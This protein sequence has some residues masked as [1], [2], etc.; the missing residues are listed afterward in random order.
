MKNNNLIPFLFIVLTFSFCSRNENKVKVIEKSFSEEVTVNGKLEFT[1]D[2]Q[3]VPDSIINKPLEEELLKI[4]P[5]VSGKYVWTSNSHLV[6]LPVNGFKPATEYSIRLKDEL[7]KYSKKLFLTGTKEYSFHTPF[8]EL[9]GLQGFW[10]G[11]EGDIPL[12]NLKLE[13]NQPVE[14]S[15]IAAKSNIVINGE[16]RAFSLNADAVSNEVIFNVPDIAVSE[17]NYKANVTIDKGIKPYEG[18]IESEKEMKDQLEIISPFQLKIANIESFHDGMEGNISIYT[19]QK[20]SANNIKKHIRISPSINYDVEIEQNMFIIKSEAFDIHQKYDIGI[21]KGLKGIFG[22]ELKYEYSQPLVFGE[23][24]PTISILNKKEFYVSAKGSKLIELAI[25]NVPRIDISVVKIYENN[26]LSFLNDHPLT[27]YGYDDDYYDYY[28]YGRNIGDLGDEIFTKEVITNELPRKGNH[29][30]LELDFADK[31]T[32]YKGVYWIEIRSA[33]QQWIKSNKIIA[34]S[35]IGLIVKEGKEDITVFANSIKDA[36]PIVNAQIQF[37]GRNNQVLGESNTNDQGVAQYSLKDLDYSGFKPNLI[38]ASHAGDYNFI[39]L[40]YTQISTSRYDVGGKYN[41]PSGMD[42]FL[43]GDRDIYRP[44]EEIRLSGI[45]RNQDMMVPDDLPLLLKILSPDGKTFK[46]IRKTLNGFGSF[47]TQ[48]SLPRT[49]MTGTYQVNVQTGNEVFIGSYSFMIEEFVPD[50]L[51]VRASLSRESYKPGEEVVLDFEANSFFG[52]PAANRNYELEQSLKRKD[53]RAKGYDD[54]TFHIEGGDTY[55]SSVFREGRTN[56]DGKASESFHISPQYRYMGVLQSDLFLTVFDETGRPVNRNQS[57]NIYTQD[58]FFGIK[59]PGYYAKTG[60]PQKMNI[61]ALNKDGEL[62]SGSV[63]SVQLIK[64]EYKTVLSSSGDYYRYRSEKI[65]KELERKKMVIN[66]QSSFYSFIPELSGQYEV[67]VSIPGTD[68][69]VKQ[70]IYAYGWGSTTL[71]SFEVNNEGQIEIE[72]DKNTYNVGEKANV[73]LKTPFSGRLLI[74]VERDKLLDYF[75]L[76]TDKR[77]ANFELD[78]TGDHLPN[79]YISATLIKPHKSS[80]LPLTVAHGF[81]N[82][83]VEDPARRIAVSVYANEKVRSNTSQE[84][85]LKTIPNAAVTIA[86]VDEGI[87][88]VTGFQTPDPYHYF[89][90]KKALEVSTF[91]VYPF[92]FPELEMVRSS[93]GGGYDGLEKRLNPLDSKRFKLVAYWSGILESNKKGEVKFNFDVP[94]FSGSLRVMALAYKGNAFGNVE[95]SMVVA[96][97]IVISSSIPRFLSPGDD[98][99]MPVSLSNTTDKEANC[100]VSVHIEGP[101]SIAGETSQKIK[102]P[103]KS[104]EFVTFNVSSLNETG[105]GK[106]VVKVQSLGESFKQTTE[107]S[108]RPASPLQKRSGAGSVRAGEE[109]SVNLNTAGFIPES[110]EKKL[111]VSNNPLV[112]F[113]NSLDYLVRYP[114]GCVEQTVS[115]AFPQLYFSDLMMSLKEENKKN[116]VIHNIQTALDRIMLMQLYNG[117]LTYWPGQGKETWW[118]TIYAAHFAIEARKAGYAVDEDFLKKMMKY[119]KMQLSNKKTID[120][121]YNSGQ[122]RKIAPHEVPYSLFVLSLAGDPAKSVMN[123]YSARSEQLSLDGK[124]LLAAAY[125]LSGD[126]KKFRE[127]LP[128]SFDGEK[129]DPSFGGSFYSYIRDEALALYVLLETDPDHSQVGEMAK[130]V[131]GYLRNKRYL[132]TQERAFGLMALGKMARK[133]A[134][135]NVSAEVYVENRKAGAINNNT[136]TLVTKDLPSNEVN[137]QSEGKGNIYYFWESEGISADGTYQE[138]DS[139][140][141]IRRNL[142]DRNG[143]RLSDLNFT[144]NDLVLVE[145]ELANGT[146]TYIENIAISDI[147]PACFEIENPGIT[148]LPPGMKWPNKK[149][150]PEYQDIRDDRINLFTNLGSTAYGSKY[151]YYLVRVVSK[152]TFNMGPVGADAMYNGEYHSYHG[153]NKVYVNE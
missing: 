52:P 56:Q 2:K 90:Q 20:V 53:F 110:S 19:T 40:D 98:L 75:S 111:I 144:Q 130:H 149:S 36:T 146:N 76:E 71:S 95:K 65:E 50:R 141:K 72:T 9:S 21:S 118:G 55:F 140:I 101:F 129:S 116:D 57:V 79:V 39:P 108:V 93:T 94:E 125:G 83:M 44:G 33:E 100:D 122:H 68:T 70:N 64:Y 148:I 13:F 123:Y 152:G 139:Y 37:I 54:Y 127:I 3:I 106:I 87:L 32:Q 7:L 10:S 30:L 26:I 1:F 51:K 145:L 63:A 134:E 150:T 43:Y 34:I 11:N 67:R 133:I 60:E 38:T 114:Y 131:S 22:G 15:L 84:I 99:I 82:I 124:Y 105:Q 69:Y 77:A 132:N 109:I 89:Y 126:M 119:I 151:F 14:P 25:Y 45:I 102:I 85:N 92:L 112:Q 97:P 35:D 143:R 136:L 121:F 104:E 103:K 27:N 41:N 138:E 23:V 96:D 24:E 47:E 80:D 107:I 49:A 5:T 16:K 142:Y 78:L 58:E 73:L 153:G 17:E 117:G 59:Y 135:S 8:L 147:L 6:F 12:L 4:T 128:S 137:I 62:L 48:F 28:Y 46:T 120:Y 31:L 88:Q 61:V 113:S 42:I 66:E 81:Q 91:N 18:S 29:R 115:S 74:T 86:V